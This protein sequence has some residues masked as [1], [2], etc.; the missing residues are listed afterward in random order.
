MH[1]LAIAKSLIDTAV[2]LLPAPD[3]Q[4]TNLCIQLGALAGV[5]KEELAFGFEVMSK[6][7][8]CA[9]AHLQ[10]EEIAAMAH[11]PHCDLD[12][13][14]ED[15]GFL[16]CPRCGTGAVLV[17]QGKELL[18]SSIEIQDEAEIK[19]EAEGADEGHFR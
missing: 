9:G 8:P 4:I 19:E 15:A 1:E 10:I 3:C 7:T 5:S 12:F 11:C 2:S 14:P 17:L 18:I 6:A 13:S 16:L